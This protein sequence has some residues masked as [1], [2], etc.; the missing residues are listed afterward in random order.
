MTWEKQELLMKMFS[1]MTGVMVTVVKIHLTVFLRMSVIL[2]YM[3]CRNKVYLR[4][5]D[6]WYYSMPDG[7]KCYGEK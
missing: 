4:K 3:L 6:N 5:M 1:I 7:Y 2:L